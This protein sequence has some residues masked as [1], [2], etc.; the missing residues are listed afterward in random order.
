MESWQVPHSVE[1]MRDPRPRDEKEAVQLLE[2]ING[3]NSKQARL[4]DPSHQLPD[5]EFFKPPWLEQDWS[6]ILEPSGHTVGIKWPQLSREGAEEVAAA[7]P[8]GD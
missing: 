2:G 7:E 3:W 8:R 4:Q 5:V 6:C 1:R